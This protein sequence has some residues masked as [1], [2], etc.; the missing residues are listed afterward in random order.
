MGSAAMI[1]TS[2]A[3]NY[4]PSKTYKRGIRHVMGK[5]YWCEYLPG[6]PYDARQGTIEPHELTD[7][8]RNEVVAASQKHM[9]Y[10]DWPEQ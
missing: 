3:K 4:D 9:H 1:V 8:F 10:V 5:F 6:A 2:T 7:K